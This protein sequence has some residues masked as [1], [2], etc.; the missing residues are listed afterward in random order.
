MLSAKY[1]YKDLIIEI[2]VL[3]SLL[4]AI[5]YMKRAISIKLVYYILD[6]H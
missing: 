5:D 3:R 2:L 1:I 4:F 6:I